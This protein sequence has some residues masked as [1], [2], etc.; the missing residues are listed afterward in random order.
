MPDQ[1][2]HDGLWDEVRHDGLWDQVRH[3]G[4]VSGMTV[5]SFTF[6]FFSLA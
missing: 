2:R 3:D 1:V 4:L 5:A 6:H